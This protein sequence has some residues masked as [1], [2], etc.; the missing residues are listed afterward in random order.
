V[1][2]A[3]LH[4]VRCDVI[5]TSTSH[6]NV[7]SFHWRPS[8]WS[9]CV[10]RMPL[11]CC[12]CYRMRRVDCVMVTGG[13]DVTGGRPVPPFYC[14]KW[15]SS[16]LLHNK[17][18][19]G[20]HNGYASSAAVVGNEEWTVGAGEMVGGSGEEAEERQACLACAQDCVLSVWSEWSS[21]RETC[22][23]TVRQRLRRVLVASSLG[24]TSCDSL[25]LVDTDECVNLPHCTILG[26]L[27]HLAPRHSWLAGPWTSCRIASVRPVVN[28]SKRMRHQ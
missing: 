17:D 20:S 8:A 28:G 27:G 18:G 10:H 11:T 25:G 2:C 4:N 22:A 1:L 5:I 12:E 16:V 9:G 26:P 19:G 7:T 21:C 14:R 23:P 13:S 3:L 24:G 6:H 15:A